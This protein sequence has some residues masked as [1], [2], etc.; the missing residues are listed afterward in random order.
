MTSDQNAF[1]FIVLLE[2]IMKN[3][4]MNTFVCIFLKEGGGVQRRWSKGKRRV[5]RRKKGG[6]TGTLVPV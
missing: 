4:K 5:Q 6:F 3:E 1:V 2:T